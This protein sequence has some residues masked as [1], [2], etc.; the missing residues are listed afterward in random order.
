MTKEL[1]LHNTLDHEMILINAIHAPIVPHTDLRTDPL[2]DTILA[3]DIDHDLIQE[4]KFSQ[5]YKFLQTTFS[6]KRF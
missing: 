3:L 4:T 2:I 6:T 5:I 1:L